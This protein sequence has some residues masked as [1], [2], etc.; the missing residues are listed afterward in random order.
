[1]KQL[2]AWLL[3]LKG[4]FLKNARERDLAAEIE[5][6]LQMH[7]DD[8]LRA[9][10]S[11][12]QARRV[13]ILKLGGVDST[14][15][16]CRDRSTI[17]FLEN[18][19]QDLRF[20]VRQLRKN[21]GF[22]IT[23]I[24]MVTLGIGASVAIFGFTDAALIKPLPYRNPTRLLH[25][26]E[27]NAQIPRANLSYPDYLDWKRLNTVF[28][29]LDVY[30]MRGYMLS[31]PTGAEVLVGARVSDGF[32]RT[33]GITPVL[34]SDF[35]AGEDLPGAPN[36]LI[37]SFASWQ[38]RFG[39][40]PDI[41]GQPLTL[42]DL[43]YI[44]V[45]VLPRDFHFAPARNVEFW[46]TLHASGPCE[47]RR[48]CH[49]LEG[50]GRLKDG[51]S[52]STALAGMTLIAKE[53]ESQYPDSNRGQGAS[54]LPLS[55]VIVGDV[56]PILLVLLGGAGLLLLIA[57]VNVASLLVVRFETRKRELAVRRALGAS[58]A[59]LIRQFVT[60][61]LVVVVAGSVLGLVSAHWAM[62][63]LI[64][65]IPTDM[66][67]SMPYLD[68]LAL[69]FR[70]VAFA[71]VISLLAAALFS[72]TPTLRLSSLEIREGMAE[73][74]RGSAGN[75]W[76]RM[77]SKLVVLELATAMVLLVGAG[78]LGKSFYR[79]L[80]VEPGFQ[81]NHLITLKVAAPQASYGKDEQALALGRR[82]LNRIRSLPGVTSAATTSTL[83]VS[84][85]GNTDWIRFVGRPYNGEHNEVNQREVTS[86]YFTTLQAKL[87]RGRPF[88]DAEDAS[89]PRVVIINQTL[90]RKY[91]P[92]EDPIGKQIGD[93]ELTSDSIKEIIGIVEDIRE[94]ALDSEIWPAVYY[95][96]NQYP[97]NNFSVV[98]RTS[99]A[100]QSVLPMLGFA[101]HEI[102][103][104]ISTS[105]ETT[106]KERVNNSPTVYL[107]RSSAW[108]VG[109][110]AAIALLLGVVGLYGVIAYSV[111]QRTREIGVRIA[112]GAQ[113][114]SVYQLIL[115]EAGGLAA[116]GI[117][118][119]LACSV[120]AASLMRKL[121][122]GT[123][124]WDVPT[125][126][127]VA[128][129]L[130]ISALLASYLPARRAASLNP[131]EALR[132]E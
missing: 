18:L 98:I 31:T 2:R 90:A 83:P 84:F 87:L 91:F 53:L 14:K 76:R 26:T 124:P 95:P 32:F 30:G 33:L 38:T 63:L 72:I 22:T 70:V 77:G 66:M 78:L 23:A 92:G 42:N 115:R 21:P 47:R 113:R 131:I 110:F 51:V 80:Q 85:N 16:A 107:H 1:M 73:G 37:L 60:E 3:R 58:T 120:A 79:L 111:S 121:L 20:T 93:T 122:F 102:D 56:R 50:I 61:G 45:G 101:I 117:V 105:G 48:S 128:G 43:P 35:Y 36:T 74:S 59:R 24:L 65:L 69:N 130:G 54:V 64:K 8:N 17:P 129:V 97:D 52:I 13:A 96:F 44:I 106:M 112:L 68:D 118:I 109:G 82:I 40:R 5:S 11:T 46:A 108:L 12:E 86:D 57:C 34:G 126:V 81:P 6:H 116:A 55:E 114:R 4:V 27:N 103:A 41:I 119:G 25:V 9:G 123:P 39:G 127:A 75:T 132:A 99:Q 15:E 19:L 10:M 71:G 125:L 100:E 28:S 29:S 7:I 94:G 89:K 49:F 104:S 62:Q 88:T 67:A